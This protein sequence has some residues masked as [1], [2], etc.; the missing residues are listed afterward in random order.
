MIDH[1]FSTAYSRLC[2]NLGHLSTLTKLNGDSAEI[3]SRS[4][5][6]EFTFTYA[7]TA[8]LIHLIHLLP[9][10]NSFD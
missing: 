10:S 8:G 2:F 7:G 5:L 6:P 3:V 1:N 4:Q 9:W